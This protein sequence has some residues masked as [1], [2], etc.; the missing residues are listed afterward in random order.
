MRGL[1]HLEINSFSNIKYFFSFNFFLEFLVFSVNWKIVL[2][3][4]KFSC[5]QISTKN[6]FDF[7]TGKYLGRVNILNLDKKWLFYLLKSNG[8][9]NNYSWG[10][11]FG[12]LI[13]CRDIL[14]LISRFDR[15]L[16]LLSDTYLNCN[17]HYR[18]CRLGI[19]G[20]RGTGNRFRCSFG[21]LMD[22]WKRK[23]YLGQ[24]HTDRISLIQIG[25]DKMGWIWS[26]IWT[27]LF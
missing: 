25:S 16:K 18:V 9:S 22:S 21:P 12:F 8:K 26:I 3:P 7:G 11:R 6:F 10:G 5:C 24:F 1:P 4:Q 20:P 17:L 23:R 19:H 2:C 13:A 14:K 27:S 15:S